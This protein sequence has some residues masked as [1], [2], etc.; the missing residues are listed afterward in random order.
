MVSDKNEK[1]GWQ[2]WRQHVLLEIKRLNTNLE[3]LEEKNIEHVLATSV[4]LSKLK[5]W[6]AVYGAVAGI[7]GMLVGVVLREVVS[8]W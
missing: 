4:E 1:N 2:E 8:R 6:A 5:V 7:A 3:K